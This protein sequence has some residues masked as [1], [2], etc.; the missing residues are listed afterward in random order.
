MNEF[1]ADRFMLMFS[2]LPDVVSMRLRTMITLSVSSHLPGIL[3]LLKGHTLKMH[4]SSA[5][6]APTKDMISL[7]SARLSA[8]LGPRHARPLPHTDIVALRS[9]AAEGEN[10]VCLNGS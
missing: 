3:V 1:E 4:A 9:N 10:V 8:A 6:P 7:P 5:L 2:L